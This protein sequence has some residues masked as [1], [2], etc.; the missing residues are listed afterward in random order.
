MVG[1]RDFE[2]VAVDGTTLETRCDSVFVK[3]LAV[4]ASGF[5]AGSFSFAA[6]L[7]IRWQLSLGHLSTG[8]SAPGPRLRAEGS[9]L[10]LLDDDNVV[11]RSALPAPVASVF[12]TVP[13]ATWHAN[14]RT[15]GALQPYPRKGGVLD[16]LG[17][18]AIPMHLAANPYATAH[19][20]P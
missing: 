5:P 17:G 9:S 14:E 12:A 3:W 16:H 10:L 6:T 4:A 15:A 18:S 20:P 7:F 13:I 8:T 1:R 11:W 19:H 2:V